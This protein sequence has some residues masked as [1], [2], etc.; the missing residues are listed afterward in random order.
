MKYNQRS[1]KICFFSGDI[2]RCGGTERIAIML[3]N[4]LIH[5]PGTEITFLSWSEGSAEPFFPIDPRIRRHKL[6][7][8][9]IPFRFFYGLAAKILKPFLIKNNITHLIDIDA[10][11][12]NVSAQAVAQTDCKLISWEH[13][14]YHENLGCKLRDRGRK[15][16]KDHA[17]AI[18][19]LTEGDRKQYLE[20]PSSARVVTI[21][22]AIMPPTE[23]ETA[24]MPDGPFILSVGRLCY[25]KGFDQ[26][27]AIAEKIFTQHENWKWVI[28]GDGPDYKKLK[29]EIAKRGLSEKI[30]L[31]GRQ[32]TTSYYQNAAFTVMP[33]RFEGF[34]LVLLE[35]LF[36]HCPVISFD[37]KNGPAEVIRDGEN[38]FLVPPG[39]TETL[40]EKIRFL[41]NDDSLRERFSRSARESICTFSPENFF[42]RWRKLLADPESRS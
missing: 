42:A 28:V 6:F 3:A 36:L 13:F 40:T 15:L 39:D 24:E 14:H 5:D 18:V 27:P 16:A 7:P 22:N 34:P 10:I 12:T 17:D 41:M 11:L 25:Q 21:P 32:A 38:G 8:F 29:S 2:T 26:I 37:C 31:A 19:T 1:E 20:T 9:N 33:S 30:I 23:N 35:S 4:E